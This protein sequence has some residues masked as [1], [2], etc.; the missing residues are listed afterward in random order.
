MA[1]SGW[2]PVEVAPED[3]PALVKKIGKEKVEFPKPEASDEVKKLFEETMMPKLRDGLFGKDSKKII[4][5]RKKQK[6]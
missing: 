6:N 1:A 5:K 3:A 4:S 2:I